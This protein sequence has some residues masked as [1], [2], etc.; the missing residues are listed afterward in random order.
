MNNNNNINIDNSSIKNS[1]HIIKSIQKS[2][3][4]NKYIIEQ[5]NIKMELNEKQMYEKYL[6]ISKLTDLE[7]NNL[8]YKNAIKLE[9]RNYCAYYVSLIRSK[10]ILFFS[11][12]PIFDYNSRILKIFLF[13][14]NFTVNFIVNALFFNDNTMHKIYTDGGSFNFIYNIPQILYSS[15]ISGFINAIIKILALTD[16][17]FS[18]LKRFQYMNNTNNTNIMIKSKQTIHMFRIKFLFFFL[19]T[20]SLLVL[21]WFYLACFCAVYKNTQLHLIKDTLISFGTS[22]IYPFGIYLIPGIFRMNAL[23]GKNREFMYKVS[24]LFQMI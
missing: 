18:Q 15:L 17:G 20:L 9:K 21:F 1:K 8:P 10:H 2:E 5:N 13:F 19:I 7:L 23:K 6:L 14:F 24:K 16:S 12:F 11:F 4:T 3:D 22:M